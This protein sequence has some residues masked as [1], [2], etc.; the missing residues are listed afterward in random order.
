VVQAG[1]VQCAG[2]E[3]TRGVRGEVWVYSTGPEYEVLSLTHLYRPRD[4]MRV[5]P[6]DADAYI[7]LSR[8]VGVGKA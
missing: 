7:S 8:C 6:I 1:A 4:A 3:G 2:G 5:L